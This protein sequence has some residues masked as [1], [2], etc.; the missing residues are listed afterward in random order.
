MPLKKSPGPNFPMVVFYICYMTDVHITFSPETT[1]RDSV[2]MHLEFLRHLSSCL[3]STTNNSDCLQNTQKH[4]ALGYNKQTDRQTDRQT[5]REYESFAR[6]CMNLFG[7]KA[8]DAMGDNSKLKNMMPSV[9]RESFGGTNSQDTW[10]NTLKG[11]TRV[12]SG[13]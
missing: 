12:Q 6:L 2:S 8:G 10:H 11:K 7:S 5:E 13:V 9:G 4:I 3:F 1:Q